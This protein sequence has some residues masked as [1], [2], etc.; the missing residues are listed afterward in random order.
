MQYSDYEKTMDMYKGVEWM[1]Q[2][3]VETSIQCQKIKKKIQRILFTI[4]GVKK[5]VRYNKDFINKGLS[6]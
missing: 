3:Q 1:R 5:I 6:H 2:I 4:T